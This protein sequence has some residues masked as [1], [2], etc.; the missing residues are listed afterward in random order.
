MER[1]MCKLIR[2]TYS[3]N[4]H[5]VQAAVEKYEPGTYQHLVD[6]IAKHGLAPIVGEVATAGFGNNLQ[7]TLLFILPEQQK[8]AN[9]FWHVRIGWDE[10]IDIDALS[11]IRGN[12]DKRQR[13]ASL[14]GLASRI[15]DAIEL[16]P[17]DK[18]LG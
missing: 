16:L 17:G 13:V 5:A 7:K 2:D 1:V 10:R 15:V 3:K 12:P 6:V 11:F 9:R 8:P 18:V 4:M 14:M